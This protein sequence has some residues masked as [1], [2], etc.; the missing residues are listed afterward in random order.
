MSSSVRA[1]TDLIE[2]FMGALP[3]SRRFHV[4][5]ESPDTFSRFWDWAGLCGDKET[6]LETFASRYNVSRQRQLQ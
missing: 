4:S 1:A 5:I 3:P 6:A 2:L